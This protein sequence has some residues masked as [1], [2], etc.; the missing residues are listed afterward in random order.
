MGFNK[1]T[2][3]IEKTPA[4]LALFI[5]VLILMLHIVFQFANIHHPFFL[6]LMDAVSNTGLFN[7]Y[8]Y[9]HII[10]LIFA[11]L[12]VMSN[13]S[14]KSEHATKG[15]AVIFI[16]FG[17]LLFFGAYFI[18]LLFSSFGKYVYVG[19]MSIGYL[20]T[21]TGMITTKRIIDNNLLKDQFNKENR[22]FPQEKRKI[23]NEYSVNIKTSDGFINIINPFRATMVLG[24]PGSGKSYAIVEEFIRQH[25]EKDFSMLVYDFKY[26][27]LS[28]VAYNYLKRIHQKKKQKGIAEKRKI[29][30]INFTNPQNSH[31]TNPIAPNLIDAMPDAIAAATS[32]MQNLDKSFIKKQD[33]FNNSAVNLIASCIWFLRKFENGQFCTLPHVLRLMSIGDEALFNALIKEE[34][35][36]ALLAPFKDALDKQA[37]EQLA[38]QTASA[39]IYLSRMDSPELYWILSKNEVSLD[40]N[41]PDHPS[42]LFLANHPKTKD[43]YSAVFGLISSTIAKLVNQKDRVPLSLIIDELPTIYINGL[44]NLIATARSNKVSTLLSFQDLAQLERD[45]GKEVA[46]SIFN[47]VGNKVVGSVVA[48]TAKKISD[49]IG[50][51]MQQRGSI[52]HSS[53][54]TS[55]GV[56]T[57][58]EYVIPPEVITQ[59]SQGEF[60]GLVADT[61]TQ[62]LE[63]KR[64]ISDVI[65]SKKT[66]TKDPIPQIP[67]LA[68]LS[69]DEFYELMI[70]NKRQIFNDIDYIVEKLLNGY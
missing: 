5:S 63:Q 2:S 38:G 9:P 67:N 47:T 36:L 19:T 43:S 37:Y 14:I 16:V 49:M 8:Y 40:I 27:D 70:K 61:Y 66:L 21:I 6:K 55:T 3:A 10:A 62:K 24:T 28:N 39:R 48:E 64:F 25:I 35:V 41:N 69:K 11:L 65:V 17:L 7:F 60:C 33:F 58:L 20:L 45:Y 23:E 44:D 50:K 42:I 56:S 4:I 12:Y 31:R 29:Y 22:K 26:P 59:L 52:N 57:T 68:K 1:E 53:R 34:E 46:N 13:K 54:G 51:A 32:L 18:F 30:T 15:R